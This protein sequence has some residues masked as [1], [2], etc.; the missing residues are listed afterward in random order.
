ML[1]QFDY[2]ILRKGEIIDT[3]YAFVDID[4]DEVEEIIDELM[5]CNSK[6]ELTD[7]P[8][9]YMKRFVNSALEDALEIYPDFDCEDREYTVM[10]SKYL[11]E[12]LVRYLPDELIDNFTD[13]MFE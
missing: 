2:C 1:I 9:K 11:P 7:I 8:D 3:C 10:L 5:E 12:G 6:G 13:E 4:G